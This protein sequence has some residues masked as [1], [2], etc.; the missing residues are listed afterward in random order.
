MNPKANKVKKAFLSIDL[1]ASEVE[2]EENKPPKRRRLAGSCCTLIIILAFAGYSIFKVEEFIANP[3]PTST[4]QISEIGFNT[5]IPLPKISFVS[6]DSSLSD[7]FQNLIAVGYIKYGNNLAQ[8][9]SLEVCRLE[10]VPESLKQT[11]I[12]CPSMSD[13]VIPGTFENS[14]VTG[15]SIGITIYPRD[16]DVLNLNTPQAFFISI[17]NPFEIDYIEGQFVDT[18]IYTLTKTSLAGNMMMLATLPFQ[19]EQYDISPDYLKRWKT[20]SRTKYSFQPLSTEFVMTGGCNTNAPLLTLQFVVSPTMITTSINYP[21]ILDLFANLGAIW[22]TGFGII[23]VAFMLCN[24]YEQKKLKKKKPEKSGAGVEL[25]KSP[26][27]SSASKTDRIGI[28]LQAQEPD[29]PSSSKTEQIGIEIQAQEPVQAPRP[30][31]L[32]GSRSKSPTTNMK[33]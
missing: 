28:E 33:K 2:E 15:D 6:I 30:H 18:Y 11:I 10:N 20:H 27:P 25:E 31:S 22:T 1:F 4:P 23:M 7:G 16:C 24:K 32:R 26:E 12:Y 21:T 3:S 8:R 29:S 14:V 13:L 17:I 19:I 9:F 5:S